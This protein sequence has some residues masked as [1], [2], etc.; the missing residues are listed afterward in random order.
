M[1]W[2]PAFGDVQMAVS[3]THRFGT[4]AM[5]LS[6]FAA[7]KPGEK[8]CEL[9]T[10]CGLIALR[11]AATGIPAAVHG[12][13]IAPEA[14]DLARTSAAAFDGTPRPTFAVADWSHPRD[15]APAGSYRRVVCNPPYFPPNSGGISE[16]PAARL[17]RHEQPDTLPSLCRAAAWL[18]TSG[19]TFCLC[20]RPD[21][22]PAV[23][24]AL[25]AC[26]L[27]PKLLQP[28]QNRADTPTWLFLLAARKDG[29][30]GLS[31]QAPLI[32]QNADGSLSE[33]YREIYNL[34]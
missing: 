13:D 12:I 19:G 29:K 20:H 3:D 21:R 9:G 17:A 23:L 7:P 8:I 6:H 10:G 31:W 11:L 14:I 22:L 33:V 4:D 24:S 16:H 34:R 28:V 26:R 25:T 2:I 27:E 15:I 30:P 5:L 32:L 18:L 1:E